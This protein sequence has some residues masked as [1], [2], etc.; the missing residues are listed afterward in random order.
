MACYSGGNGHQ[1]VARVKVCTTAVTKKIQCAS[2]VGPNYIVSCARVDRVG[3]LKDNLVVP[4]DLFRDAI[5]YCD[6]MCKIVFR[7]YDN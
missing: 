5:A 7:R 3:N 1:W 6:G 2:V 4:L